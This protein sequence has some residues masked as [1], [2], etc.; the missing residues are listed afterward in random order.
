M[1]TLIQFTEPD[2]VRWSVVNDGVMGGRSRSEIALADEGT[3]LFSGT[4]SLENNGGFA[5]VRA[6]FPSMDLSGFR[7]V[8]L[9]VRGDGRRYQLRLRTDGSFDGLAYRAEFETREGEWMEIFLPFDDFEPSF[10]GS[11]PRRAAPLDIGGIRQIGFLIG[12]KRAGLFNLQI[13]WVKAVEAS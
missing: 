8:L 11:V 3:A 10:R 5:S 2:E 6:R 1:R 9:R 13:A 12:D 7:G 4:V